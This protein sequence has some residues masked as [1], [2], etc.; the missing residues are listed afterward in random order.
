[1]AGSGRGRCA[2]GRPAEGLERAQD[3]RRRREKR[4]EAR[5]FIRRK[6]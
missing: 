5:N 1:M 4:G 6:K 3:E 2:A